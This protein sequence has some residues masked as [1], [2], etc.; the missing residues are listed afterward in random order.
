MDAQV[1][2]LIGGFISI[3]AA[4]PQVYK[5]ILTGRTKDLTYATNVVSYIGSSMG[6]YYGFAIGHST[7]VACNLYSILVNTCLL[8]TKLYF[9]VVY[10]GSKDKYTYLDKS[11]RDGD[12]SAVL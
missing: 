7:I 11:E 10:P 3:S 4:L 9:E 6:V 1:V 8:S 5:C 2:G 12:Y